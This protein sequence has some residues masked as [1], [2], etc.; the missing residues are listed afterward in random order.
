MGPEIKK[1]PK[2]DVARFD[3]TYSSQLSKNNIHNSSTDFILIIENNN[4]LMNR[5]LILVALVLK[6]LGK[7]P[8]FAD[9]GLRGP[10]KKGDDGVL[11]EYLRL[12][13][14]G[15]SQNQK[16]FLISLPK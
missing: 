8:I 1:R 15:S 2:P 16:G 12:S 11:A 10:G 14:T 13:L 3:R 4:T 7:H 9:L 6:L 5:L